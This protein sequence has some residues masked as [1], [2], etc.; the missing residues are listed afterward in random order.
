MSL[1]PRRRSLPVAGVVHPVGPASSPTAQ[2]ASRLRKRLLRSMGQCL[3]DFQMIESG[4]RT[5]RDLGG[6]AG[7]TE[8]TQALLDRL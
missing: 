3:N 4:D 8:F 7:T 6:E 2:D 5:T 1:E